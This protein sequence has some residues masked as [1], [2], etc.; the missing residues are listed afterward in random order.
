M[1]ELPQGW[2]SVALGALGQWGSGGTPSRGNQSYYVNGTIPWLVIGDLNDGYVSSAA[3]KITREGLSNSS[4]KLLPENTLLVAMYGSIGKLGITKFECATNQAIAFC[5]PAPELVDLKYL[6]YSV[7]NQKKA[8]IEQGQGGAQQNISQGILKLHEIPLAPRSEQ[9]RI[10]DKLD[11]LLARVDATR[12]R[13]D[14]IPT[15]LKRFRQSV[16]AAATSGQLTEDWRQE[17][18]IE[19]LVYSADPVHHRADNDRLPPK[20]Q[21]GVSS[22][23]WAQ[24]SIGEVAKEVRY[25]TSRRCSYAEP[26]IGVLRIPNIGKYGRIDVSDLKRAEF[27]RNEISKLA[28][29]AG[30]LLVIRSNGSVD[31]VG[32]TSIVTKHEE[33]LLFAGYLMRLRANV[34][35]VQPEYLLISLSEP[36]QRER[37][38]L[39]S[40]STSGVN[41]LNAEELRGLPI[42]LPPLREQKEIVRRVEALFSLADRVEARYQAAWAQVDKLTSSVLA[43]AFRGEL[44]PQD[45]TDEPAD[46]LL[47][48]IR[49]SAPEK[50]RSKNSSKKTE[51]A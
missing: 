31:L 38:E 6:F 19:S 9:K 5:K 47:A 18:S 7:M 37:I 16:L 1:S 24:A 2:A 22:K 43:K 21:V 44:V 46:Q 3:T 36:E 4:A 11:A 8:L 32:K 39:I 34:D 33:G 29:K 20:G 13:L 40:K 48:R 17:R 12:A 50:P 42:Q 41:N 26:G 27:D 25:G 15:L 30:D 35:I 45:P 49:A 23:G 14:R 10:A 28:L 51:S